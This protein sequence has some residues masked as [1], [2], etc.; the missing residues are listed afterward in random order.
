M[1]H[2]HRTLAIMA[3]I[4]LLS[5][6]IGSA[7]SY[8]GERAISNTAQV[9]EERR[10]NNEDRGMAR[11]YKEQLEEA[12]NALETDYQRGDWPDTAELRLFELPSTEDRGRIQALLS[13]K[14]VMTVREA[15]TSMQDVDVG[16]TSF[17]GQQIAEENKSYVEE[18]IANLRSG[19]SA[20]DGLTDERSKTAHK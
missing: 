8:F 7:V 9:H 6:V 2:E 1:Q 15:D 5:G 20:L 13:P 19:A 3:V 4:G 18:Y 16:I 11:V 14:A 12:V 10:Q 17:S